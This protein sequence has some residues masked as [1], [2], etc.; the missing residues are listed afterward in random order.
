MGPLALWL[1]PASMYHR[2]LE[3]TRRPAS[4]YSVLVFQMRK[5]SLLIPLQYSPIL[6]DLTIPLFLPARSVEASWSL[7]LGWVGVGLCVVT[8]V[9]IYML[10]RLMRTLPFELC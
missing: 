6:D 8:S 4:S 10:S 9:S 3:F 7:Y 2:K 5:Y 1:H